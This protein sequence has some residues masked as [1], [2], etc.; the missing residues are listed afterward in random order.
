[1]TMPP[2]IQLDDVSY[3]YPD[4]TAGLTCCSLKI[5]RGSRT[6]LMG[7]NGAGKTTLFMHLNGIFIPKSGR[8]LFNGEPYDYSRKG[9]KILRSKVGLLFQNP[10]SQLFSATVREDVSFGPMNLGLARED[11][12]RRVESALEATGITA[13]AER[14]V[15]SLSFGQ[16]K[17]ACIAGLLAMEPEILVL[18]EAMSGLDRKMRGDL[19]EL[20]DRLHSRGMTIILSTHDIDFAYSW[21]DRIH[22]LS[23]GSCEASWDAER[24]PEFA[25]QLEANG[26][27]VPEAVKLQR[28]L[29]ERGLL[30]GDKPLRSVA[31]IL[32]KF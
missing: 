31:E 11:V 27:G 15:H 20:L 17:R 29:A 1:M 12:E 10:D 14:P 18:D 8:L 28:L 6:V 4:G 13:V 26:V 32:H 19:L 16:K 22:L 7:G 23:N 30:S 9:L 3:R 2:I 24:L 25:E 21:A 5:G